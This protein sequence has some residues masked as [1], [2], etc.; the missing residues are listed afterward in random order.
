[1]GDSQGTD[2]HKANENPNEGPTSQ[3]M[4]IILAKT[5]YILIVLQFDAAVNRGILFG[6]N[7]TGYFI[8]R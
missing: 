5:A 6:D 4:S 3:D 1:M 7:S 8:W 2:E